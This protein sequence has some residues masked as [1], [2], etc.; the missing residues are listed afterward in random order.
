MDQLILRYCSENK[1]AGRDRAFVS[2]L[3]YGVVRHKRALDFILS[4]GAARA[5]EKIDREILVILRMALYQAIGMESARFAAVNEAVELAKSAKSTSRAAGFVNAALRQTL[6]LIDKEGISGQPIHLIAAKLL[7]GQN[8]ALEEELGIQYS[9]PD[10]WAKR[11]IANFGPAAAGQIMLRC[12]SKSP[13]FIRPDYRLYKEAEVSRLL[14]HHGIQ[15]KPF[16][17]AEGLLQITEGA[18]PPDSPLITE[19][20]IQ[21]QDGASYLAATLLEVS[22]KHTAADLCCGKGIKTGIFAAKAERVI[23]FDLNYA[24]LEAMNKN[25]SRQRIANV[26]PILADAAQP[27]PTKGNFN[28]IFLD[29]PC[30]GTGLAKRHPEGKSSKTPRLI[31]DMSRVQGLMLT[32]A[33]EALAPGGRLVYAICSV[34]PEEGEMNV[35]KLLEGNGAIKRVPADSINPRLATLMTKAGDMLIPP[36]AYEMDGFYAA[37]LG[38]Q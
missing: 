35:G 12:Q 33:A 24:I 32:R 23:A 7:A 1:L 21:P 3:C 22:S 10:W 27:W 14:I 17:L 36:G 8:L 18:L 29:A 9:F 26:F 28:R 30:S 5:V 31:Q 20:V 11:W 37:V 4:K 16:P 25:M 13:V 2:E 15:A 6:R 38:R 34:E 19:G